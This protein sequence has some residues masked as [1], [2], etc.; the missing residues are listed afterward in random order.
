MGNLSQSC[1]L[2]TRKVNS[3]PKYQI[4]Y[5][6]CRTSADWKEVSF[7][8]FKLIGQGNSKPYCKGPARNNIEI[9]TESAKIPIISRCCN[10]KSKFPTENNF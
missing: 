6:A 2:P 3:L 5:N 4:Y 8:D 1:I 7:D 10:L 9:D